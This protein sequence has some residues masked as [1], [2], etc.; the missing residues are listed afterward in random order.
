M[1]RYACI[2]YNT[3]KIIHNYQNINIRID[4]SF[5]RVNFVGNLNTRINVKKYK[6]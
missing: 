5:V 3:R 6:N 1:N 4:G 2:Q